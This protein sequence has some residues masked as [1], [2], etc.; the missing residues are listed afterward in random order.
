MRLKE[1][2][3]GMVIHCKNDE[4]KKALLEEAERLEYK[5]NNNCVPTDYRMF[6]QS[7]MTI[8]FYGESEFTDFKHI[9]WSYCTELVT[10]FSDLIIPDLTAEEA[11]KLH[12]EACNGI[13][14]DCPLYEVDGY[15]S[16]DDLCFS[17]PKKAVEILAK[18]KADHEKKEQE[19]E[20]VYR[21]FGAENFGEKFFNTEEEAISRCE[22]LVKS[23]KNRQFARYERVCRLKE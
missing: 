3:P 9:T 22:E 10:E 6:K 15:D 23:Q 14:S 1:I 20:W 19:V 4:E 11:I 16:C 18:W 13:C 21:V 5:W 12:G 17:N 8:H 7:G 2:K